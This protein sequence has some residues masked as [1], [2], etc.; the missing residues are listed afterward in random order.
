[1]NEWAKL[2]EAIASLLWPALAFTVVFMFREELGSL[3]RRIKSGKIFGQEIELDQSLKALSVRAESAAAETPSFVSSLPS[4]GH[5]RDVAA[6]D[7][8]VRK[9]LDEV[10]KSPKGALLILGAEL[11][12]ELRELLWQSGWHQ[13]I[14]KATITRSIEHLE[15]LGV[16]PSNL[17]GSVRLFL[18]IRNRLLHGYGVT[19]DEVVRAIDIGLTI[20][21]AVLAIPREEHRVYHPGVEVYSDPEGRNRREGIH[22]VVLQ[23]KSPG[24]AST[25]LRVYPST[26][27][28][29]KK[30]SRVS[31]EWNPTVV[32]DRS[33][34]KH[35]DTGAIE[36]GW[37]QSMEFIG[38][39]IEDV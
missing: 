6:S 31:W 30:G 22:A 17:G 27:T 34:Y 21:K 13:G 39:N 16:V 33:W 29:F 8:A 35:P 2:L 18:E 4:A 9:V 7:N 3:L 20:L 14:G 32:I 10:P 38:R 23:T 26:R 11:E 37:G 25:Q 1:M 24:G 15:K 12:R 28:H 36:P 19:D 5:D